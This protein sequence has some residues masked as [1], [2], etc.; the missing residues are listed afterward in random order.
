MIWLI[1]IGVLLILHNIWI[2]RPD[3]LS[4]LKLLSL[5]FRKRKIGMS[6]LWLDKHRPHTLAKLTFHPD[7]TSKL[8]AL[9]DSDEV[10]EFW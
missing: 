2:S 6:Q 7:I 5:K 9:A 1:P 10:E 3:L 4:S 8:T